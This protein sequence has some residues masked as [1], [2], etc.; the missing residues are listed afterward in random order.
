MTGELCGMLE[1]KDLFLDKAKFSDWEPMYRN[2]WSQ[3]ESA[4]YMEWSVTTNEGDAKIRIQ[5]TI[6][7][8]KTHDTYL[9]YKKATGEAIGFAGVEQLAFR[10][11]Q[12][13]GICLGSEFVGQGYG[14]QVLLCLIRYC[15][16]ELGAQEFIYSTRDCNRA[17]IGLALSLGF[18]LIGTEE[19]QDKRDNQS[20]ILQKYSLKL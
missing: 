4:R 12:E 11:Y 19:K 6:D 7:F 18:R 10:T 1:T 20:Y 2:V 15:K 14:R 13:T 9:V 8:Q 5:K 17:S 16:E 3:P